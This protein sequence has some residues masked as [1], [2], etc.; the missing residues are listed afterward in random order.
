MPARIR[1]LEV[2]VA[3]AAFWVGSTLAQ[4]AVVDVWFD[5]V[6]GSDQLGD[7]SRS[8]PY[9]TVA[10]Y[11][12]RVSRIEEHGGDIIF[13]DADGDGDR[14]LI[15]HS[16][17]RTRYFRNDSRGR[18]RDFT[19]SG[20]VVP[21]LPFGA[22]YFP[23]DLDGD[24]DDDLV[25]ASRLAL[26]PFQV[27]AFLCNQA[28]SA[29]PVF[30]PSIPLRTVNG[31]PVTHDGSSMGLAISDVDRDGAW[32][33]MV[34][35]SSLSASSCSNGIRR[36]LSL[37]LYRGRVQSGVHQLADPVAF[38]FA[39]GAFT[40]LVC[41][42]GYGSAAF[43]DVSGDGYEDLVIS[44]SSTIYY[45]E[46][47]RSGAFADPV[48]IWTVPATDTL[49][50]FVHHVMDRYGDGRSFVVSSGQNLGVFFAENSGLHFSQHEILRSN[51]IQLGP[52]ERF[53]LS[54]LQS[55]RAI[56]RLHLAA[57]VY[58][59]GSGEHFPW[60]LNRGHRLLG[61]GRTRTIVDAGGFDLAVFVEEQSVQA[62]TSPASPP[63]RTSFGLEDMSLR[64]AARG[65]YIWKRGQPTLRRLRIESSDI[66]F[67]LV[68]SGSGIGSND[69]EVLVEQVEFVRNEV[70]IEQST[71]YWT[72]QQLLDCH[73]EDNAVAMRVLSR[74]RW[75]I[76]NTRF[77]SSTGM[78]VGIEIPWTFIC[79]CNG[80][81]QYN[82]FDV[83]A[84]VF[85]GNADHFLV[86]PSL[87]SPTNLRADFR[88]CTFDGFG[89]VLSTQGI[90]GGRMRFE[91]CILWSG[92]F[93]PFIGM[94]SDV[95]VT[96]CTLQDVNW[97]GMQS[98]VAIAPQYL[99]SAEDGHLAPGSALRGLGG[100]SSSSDIDGEERG[101]AASD[102]G[103]DE[104]V[105]PD[106]W[107]PRAVPYGEASQITLV[108]EPPGFAILLLGLGAST[109]GLPFGNGSLQLD[110]LAPTTVYFGVPL[111]GNGMATAP[112]A[113]PLDATLRGTDLLA[114]A[115]FAHSPGGSIELAPTR[116]VRIRVD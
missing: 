84:C 63:V 19:Y 105:L 113:M 24:G 86:A 115:A 72:I 16:E 36:S 33:L 21:A 11:L 73:F 97:V 50:V 17:E 106:L 27:Q 76:R 96:R 116:V 30:S 71:N 25:S 13:L 32:D 83:E 66:G 15:R 44:D 95:D 29:A 3:V 2:G 94:H 14:D 102:L 100:P 67:Q 56:E 39:S 75:R 69:G 92:G 74:G 37:E 88:H 109:R 22:R 31:L 112:F 77:L 114:Q 82:G 52:R 49:G 78:G 53:T 70:G 20:E 90:N 47:L 58:S 6:R 110:P 59:R 12:D 7:G 104:V 79:P 10:H 91:D 43:H 99:I 93:A 26:P 107:A 48:A 51:G 4:D 65:V 9:K 98:N 28:P 42:G 23:V 34:P 61:A 55:E 81:L 89:P 80:V 60:S 1:T 62:P 85:A 38:P 45:S 5:P 18:M 68:L 46:N 108:G 87:P 8:L 101:F 41:R 54:G 111:G 40:A 57:G 64:N 103:A 35:R